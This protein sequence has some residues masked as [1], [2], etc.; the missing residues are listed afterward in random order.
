MKEYKINVLNELERL[1]ADY[2]S[3]QLRR[4]ALNIGIKHLKTQECHE[5]IN[6]FIKAHP[7]FKAYQL[8]DDKSASFFCSAFV[9]DNET[10]PIEENARVM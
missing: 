7:D 3:V 6:A 10:P 1:T 5:I 2:H 8:D 4:A 9:S